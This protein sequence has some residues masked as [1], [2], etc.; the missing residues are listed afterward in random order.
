MLRIIIGKIIKQIF[1]S[2]Y[3]FFWFR[4]HTY[5][6]ATNVSFTKRKKFKLAA[7]GTT[8]KGLIY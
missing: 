7:G 1:N 2:K 5:F 3:M 4:V 6:I 8:E